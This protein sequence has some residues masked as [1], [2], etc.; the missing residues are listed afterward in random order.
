VIHEERRRN[1]I[2]TVSSAATAMPPRRAGA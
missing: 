2:R 1:S